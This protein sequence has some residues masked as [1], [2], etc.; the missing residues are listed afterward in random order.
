MADGSRVRAPFRAVAGMAAVL[1]GGLLLVAEAAALVAGGYEAPHAVDLTD[2]GD[3]QAMFSADGL[4]PGTLVT[5]CIGVTTADNASS[6]LRLHGTQHGSGLAESLSLT[7]EAGAGGRFGDCTGFS[8]APVFDGTLAEFTTLHY[9][10]ASAVPIPPSDAGARVFRF[11]AAVRD[12]NGVQGRDAVATFTWNARTLSVE[13]SAV[14]V[15]P[16]TTPPKAPPSESLTA[17]E[18]TAVADGETDLGA[19]DLG[20]PGP[21]PAPD[22]RPTPTDNGGATP[23]ARTP[24]QARSGSGKRLLTPLHDGATPSLAESLLLAALAVTERGGVAASLLLVGGTFVVM[25]DR[26]DRRDPKLALAPVHAD[27]LLEFEPASPGRNT[28]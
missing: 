4:A 27:P 25:Q 15:E 26:I 12:D 20:A 17:A 13:G 6:E 3:G 1:F 7:V 19:R 2:D 18:P 5:A 16:A 9:D 8:G 28:P 14:P 23:V 22:D 11:T 21:Y 10:V 24:P